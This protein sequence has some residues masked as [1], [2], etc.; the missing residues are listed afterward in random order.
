MIQRIINFVVIPLM[1]VW[2]VLHTYIT[3]KGINAQFKF[4]TTVANFAEQQ[5][6]I[7]NDQNSINAD[8]INTVGA[9]QQGGY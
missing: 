2:M 5:E 8:L 6:V 1:L 3:V 9:M 4:N 7:N